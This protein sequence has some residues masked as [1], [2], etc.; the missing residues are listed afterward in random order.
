V[1]EQASLFLARH[2]RAAEAVV[3]LDAAERNIRDNPH[4]R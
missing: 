3:L 1:Y 2:K 4:K